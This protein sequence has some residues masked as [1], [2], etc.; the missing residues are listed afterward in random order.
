MFAANQGVRWAGPLCPDREGW[1]ESRNHVVSEALEHADEDPHITGVFWVDDDVILPHTAIP[2]LLE[3]D[4]DFVAGLYFQRAAPYLPV[5]ADLNE[6]GDFDFCWDFPRDV[7]APRDGVGFGCVYTSIE[8][9][10][11]VAELPES[12]NGAFTMDPNDRKTY[13]EDFLFCLR[14]KRAGFQPHVDTGVL[15]RHHLDSR[16]SDIELFER[17]RGRLLDP[18][19]ELPPG[20]K[21]V[22]D[23]EQ[24]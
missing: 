13:G 16:Y 12:V 20:M 21:V 1:R 10:R 14:A 22:T 17:F 24:E 7:V 19:A 3:H 18:A 2:R 4:L 8:L 6:K 5:M 9:L 11:A 15:C 23:A